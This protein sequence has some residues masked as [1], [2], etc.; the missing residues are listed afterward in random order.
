M[1]GDAALLRRV[2]YFAFPAGGGALRAGAAMRVPYPR[3]GRGA[4]RGGRDLPGPLRRG[5]GQ[6]PDWPG[7]GARAA[8]KSFTHGRAGGD[9]SARGRSSTARA[10][11]RPPSRSRRHASLLLPRADLL[12]LCHRRPAV[13]LVMLEA[14][15][16]ARAELRGD[17]HRSRLPPGHRAP[18]PLHRRRR[19]ASDSPGRGRG[20][21]GSHHTQ[22]AARLGTVREAGVARLGATRSLRRD[23]A[24]A[25]P[26]SHRDPRSCTARGA[27][28]RRH[29]GGGDGHGHA[30]SAETGR[31]GDSAHRRAE[32][33]CAILRMRITTRQEWSAS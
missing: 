17:R 30:A 33:G 16:P 31:D 10:S 7:L 6:G 15:G 9:V 8:S 5:R 21:S 24:G 2:P 28:T 32:T 1:A 18:G 13:A 4:L 20:D 3:Q 27:G 11:S 29:D 19:G 26:G 25:R 23:R 12:A 14:L 22:L